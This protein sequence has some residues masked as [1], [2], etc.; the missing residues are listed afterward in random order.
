MPLNPVF[1]DFELEEVTA[2]FEAWLGASFDHPVLEREWYWGDDFDELWEGLG[3]TEQST[4]A[5]LTKLFQEP[6]A[7][8]KYSLDQVAQGIW[9]LLGEASPS[10]AGHAL[11][12]RNVPLA[13]RLMCLR[14][15]PVFFRE[16]VAPAAPGPLDTEDD[17]FHGACYMWWDILPVRWGGNAPEPEFQA[18]C[19]EVMRDCLAI[20]SELCQISALHGLNHWHADYPG[21]VKQLVD[22]F[23]ADNRR[24]SPRILTYA[25]LAREGLSQ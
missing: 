1:N 5:Y 21:E 2:S 16:F 17:S 15:M 4:V 22:A 23:I 25:G 8:S 11:V 10:Q 6:G 13:E 9:F 3:L 20:P 14:S 18:A 12:Q 24:L 19:L 7:L